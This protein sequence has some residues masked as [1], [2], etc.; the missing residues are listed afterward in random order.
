MAQTSEYKQKI[1]I[2]K[3]MLTEI[4]LIKENVNKIYIRKRVFKEKLFHQLCVPA[5]QL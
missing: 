4:F 2:F 1:S 5:C 3:K